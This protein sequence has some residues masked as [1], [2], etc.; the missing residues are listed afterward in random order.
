[1]THLFLPPLLKLFKILPI[2]VDERIDA[3]Q[4]PQIG[5]VITAVGL[6]FIID[7]FEL[8]FVKVLF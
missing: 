5:L 4:P 8:G 7:A 6:Q 1:M 3:L 2:V